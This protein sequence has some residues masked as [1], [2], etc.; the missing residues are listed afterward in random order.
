MQTYPNFYGAGRVTL[1]PGAEKGISRRSLSNPAITQ[2]DRAALQR[3]IEGLQND[4]NS[5]GPDG[6]GLDDFPSYNGSNY[7]ESTDRR[8]DSHYER[9][10]G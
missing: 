5:P 9:E 6:I 10:A 1:N 3:A 7:H 4:S 2:S 8:P